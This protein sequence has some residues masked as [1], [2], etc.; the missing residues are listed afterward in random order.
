MMKITFVNLDDYLKKSKFDKLMSLISTS[1][2]EI[3]KR[4]HRYEDVQ[5]TIIADILVRYLLC[6]SLGTRNH[7]LEKVYQ[8]HLIPLP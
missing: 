3:I 4:F 2:R 8:Y 5:R 7:E 6:K 1:K